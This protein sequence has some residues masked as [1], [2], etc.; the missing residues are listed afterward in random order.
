LDLSSQ[1]RSIV[2]PTRESIGKAAGIDRE[3]TISAALTALESAGWIDRVHVPVHIGGKQTATLLRIT[4]HRRGRKTPL[5][6]HN[7][8]E[9]GKRPKGRGRKTPQDSSKEESVSAALASGEAAATPNSNE[10]Q[11][12]EALFPLDPVA[13]VAAMRSRKAAEVTA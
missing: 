11:Q 4:L 7:P 10:Q 12:P 5:T 6:E 9:G 13:M 2:T 8:V 3:K 1:G